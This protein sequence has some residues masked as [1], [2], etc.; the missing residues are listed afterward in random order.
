MDYRVKPG[1]DDNDVRNNAALPS[2]SPSRKG[3]GNSGELQAVWAWAWM[4]VRR[5]ISL[6]SAVT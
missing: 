3:E 1:N 5:L 2:P 6:L 4:R